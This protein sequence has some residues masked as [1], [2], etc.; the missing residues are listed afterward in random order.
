VNRYHAK[1]AAEVTAADIETAHHIGNPDS[2]PSDA[3]Y[4]QMQADADAAHNA[5]FLPYEDADHSP[6]LA[7]R[8]AES[9]KD[10]KRP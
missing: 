5:Q 2:Y 3:E 7:E 6:T 4:A 10:D 9:M 8:L 1:R